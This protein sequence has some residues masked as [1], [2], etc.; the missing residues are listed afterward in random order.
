MV[1]SMDLVIWNWNW[2]TLSVQADKI[3]TP[4]MGS[5]CMKKVCHH[6]K[7]IAE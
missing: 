2:M 5:H 6:L 1:P 4:V 3:P 7:V